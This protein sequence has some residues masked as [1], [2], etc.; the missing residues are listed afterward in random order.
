[1]DITVLKLSSFSAILTI[2]NTG[3][4][5]YR[6]LLF[7][8]FSDAFL[9]MMFVFG[10]GRR[11]TEVKH[12]I[13]IIS[14][15]G[16]TLSKG[17]ISVQTLNHLTEVAFVRFLN[18]KA[19]LFGFSCFLYSIVRKEVTLHRENLRSGNLWSSS[20]RAKN[21]SKLFEILVHG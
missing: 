5:S 2:L 17:F 12:T 15:Q 4:V 7:W 20:V 6:I 3:Q 11:I 8:N 19:T 13:F 9:I 14:Y 21:L 18:C 16:Y 10:L 1:M